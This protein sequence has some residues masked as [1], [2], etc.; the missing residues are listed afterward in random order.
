MS[1]ERR[2]VLKGMVLG[3]AA[4]ALGQTGLTQG[5]QAVTGSLRRP[6]LV[7][8]NDAAAQSA[9][10][11]GVKANPSVARTS[12][13]QVDSS[14]DFITAFQQR[15]MTLKGE[16]IVGLVDDASGMLL[17]DLARSSGARVHWSGQHVT[18]Q[19]ISRHRVSVT[20]NNAKSVQQFAE[21]VPDCNR[22]TKGSEQTLSASRHWA[23]SLGFA[24]ASVDPNR[25]Y[26]RTTPPNHSRAVDGHFVSFSI[27]T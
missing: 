26:L 3:S 24:L 6:V 17:L 22:P 23:S 1:I 18:E 5:A 25:R 13:L 10:V 9:F 2:S 20:D 19:G 16:R 8:V 21:F 14:L 7:L 15:L 11:D 4:L 12:L 27:E